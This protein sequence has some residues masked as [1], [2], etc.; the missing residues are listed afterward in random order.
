MEQTPMEK[1]VE[2]V[3]RLRNAVDILSGAIENGDMG[4]AFVALADMNGGC[5]GGGVMGILLTEHDPIESFR[6]AAMVKINDTELMDKL[7]QYRD[8]QAERGIEVEL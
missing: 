2:G 4:L 3:R 8:I 1:L 6:W 5:R 7:N